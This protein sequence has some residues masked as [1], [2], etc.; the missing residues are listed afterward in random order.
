MPEGISSSSK[1]NVLNARNNV[2]HRLLLRHLN[3]NVYNRDIHTDRP[4][5][6]SSGASLTVCL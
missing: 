6:S 3:M 4:H 1:W 2:P 5:L